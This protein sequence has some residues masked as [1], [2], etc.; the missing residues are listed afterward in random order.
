MI[1]R[2]NIIEWRDIAPWPANEQVEH[3]LVLSRAICEL[4][5]VPIIREQLLFRGGTALH[6]LYFKQGGR[7]SEDLDFVQLYP[8]PIGDLVDAIRGQLDSWLGEPQTQRNQGRFKLN[9]FFETEFAPV[10]KR[11]V[12]IEINT[13]E[14]F[15]VDGIVK[16]NFNIQSRWFSGET[17]VSTYSLEEL[18]GTKLRALYQRK[19]GRDLFDLWLVLKDFPELNASQVVASFTQYMGSSGAKAT[20]AEYEK[21]LALKRVDPVFNNDIFELLA[22]NQREKYNHEGALEMVQERFIKLIPGE[23]WKGSKDEKIS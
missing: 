7:F 3:D 16:R 20:R 14:H 12:K 22:E 2:A 21:N 10:S 19:K 23:P 8:G 15:S 13:R 9:Y 11:K 17:E 4:Y 6:K 1:P 5:K 18:I